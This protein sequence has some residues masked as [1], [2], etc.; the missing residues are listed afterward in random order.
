MNEGVKFPANWLVGRVDGL[1]SVGQGPFGVVDDGHRTTRH[2][3]NKKASASSERM[4]V[5]CPSVPDNGGTAAAGSQCRNEGQ[6]VGCPSEAVMNWWT[7]RRGVKSAT[8]SRFFRF[9]RF[10]TRST[11]NVEIVIRGRGHMCGTSNPCPTTGS[12][13]DLREANFTRGLSDHQSDKPMFVTLL[14]HPHRYVFP[15]QKSSQ[16]A[17]PSPAIKHQ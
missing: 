6:R 15:I 13:A 16:T 17:A 8:P 10:P 12:V 11:L 5:D 14:L 7:S 4:C 3:W 2:L 9:Q 1:S